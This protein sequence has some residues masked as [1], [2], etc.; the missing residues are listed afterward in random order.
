[1][2]LRHGMTFV[3]SLQTQTGAESGETQNVDVVLIGGGTM[4][5]TLGTL[6]QSLQPDWTIHLYERLDKAA[7]ESSNVWNN[8]GTGHSA[9]AEMNYTSPQP[10]GSVDIKR[11][12]GITEQFEVS[13]QF[14]ASQVREGVLANPRSFINTV[15]HL[16]FVWSG[17]RVSFLKTR[18]EAMRESPLYAGMEYSEDPQ[19][20]SEWIPLVMTGRDTDEPVAATRMPIGT[21]VN[22][23]EITRQM[24]NSL[25]R[26]DNFHLSV[27]TQVRDLKRNADGSWKVTVANTSDGEN[28][29]SVN[30][31]FVF[32]GAGGAALPLLQKSGI[33]EARMYGG[34]PVGGQFLYTTNPEVVAKHDAK[35]YGLAPAGSPPM[36]VPHID[37]RILDGIPAIMF[38]PF[39]TFSSKFLKNGS[40]TDL[41]RSITPNNLWPMTKVGINN[42]DLVRYLISQLRMSESGQFKEL[43]N[44]YPEANRDDWKLWTAGQRVQ[45][46]KDI[47]GKGGTLQFGTELVTG[48]EGSIAALLG[49]SPGA[50]TAPSIMLTL[51]ERVFPDQVASEA[52]QAKLKSMIPSYG[53]ALTDNP[54][55]LY[56]VRA[57]SR[58]LL[59][60]SEPDLTTTPVPKSEPEISDS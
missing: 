2:K 29:R 4:S 52:W 51:L 43:Q 16:S 54:Q 55:L 49:A 56:D 23:G 9:F 48:A 21:E 10:D 1:M 3:S 5:A 19:K 15:P 14:W 47:E 25:A 18:F 17:E 12:I 58:E 20:I 36:S 60:L 59:E 32:I 37:K 50:S 35:V 13:R 30:A 53:K 40:W 33:P 46:I 24:M 41:V 28:E 27:N 6:L 57:M 22:F 8:A 26:R 44:Y 39:A 45:T 42:L 7:E 38:G 11:A 31:R 34:F